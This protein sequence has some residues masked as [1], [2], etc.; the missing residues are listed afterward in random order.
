MTSDVSH[1]IRI[2]LVSVLNQLKICSIP[3]VNNAFV[4]MNYDLL[5]FIQVG[6]STMVGMSEIEN[7]IMKMA[8][9]K[10][11]RMTLAHH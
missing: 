3:A 11:M 4:L 5:N 7:N 1:I 10:C 6:D 8:A 2:Y 9:C